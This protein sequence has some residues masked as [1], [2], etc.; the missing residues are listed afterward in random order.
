MPT[1]LQTSLDRCSPFQV[2]L[3]FTVAL[4]LILSHQYELDPL[5]VLLSRS[6]TTPFHLIQVREPYI[7]K[8]LRQRAFGMLFVTAILTIALCVLFIFVPGH[9][10]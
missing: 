5:L 4:I 8:L 3:P 1:H 9:R 2:L 10:L 6:E 7:K